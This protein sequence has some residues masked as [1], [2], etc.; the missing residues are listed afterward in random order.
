M[1]ALLSA[2]AQVC[3]TSSLLAAPA[4]ICMGCG[5]ASEKEKDKENEKC[6]YEGTANP[7]CCNPSS[8]DGESCWVMGGD[9][10]RCTK[11][12]ANGCGL[13]TNLESVFLD[14]DG[15]LEQSDI[16][17]DEIF[18]HLEEHVLAPR[19]IIR[20]HLDIDGCREGQNKC[21]RPATDP[22][23]NVTPACTV[24]DMV[25]ALEAVRNG[26]T[27]SE[28]RQRFFETRHEADGPDPTDRVAGLKSA[29]TKV[30]EAGASLFIMSASWAPIP[31]AAWKGYLEVLTSD[32][33]YGLAFQD[34]IPEGRV[35]AVEDPGGN[36]AA[37]K[38]SAIANVVDPTR[39][40]HV[41]NSFK[42]IRQMM[43]RRGGG[44]SVKTGVGVMPEHL[45]TIIASA[46]IAVAVLN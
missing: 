12:D 22:S 21:Y 4:L 1:V 15:T 3:I 30:K 36:A 24:D 39:A 38:A 29:F 23:F 6:Y 20:E 33:K 27:P 18:E 42:Y 32:D 5:G 14:F 26:T 46:S 37:D 10:G 25:A 35:Y 2:I 40:V 7:V 31:A 19:G 16:L 11:W 17:A 45:E 34:S 13:P 44:M 41:D 43:N 9:G 8:G 28:F